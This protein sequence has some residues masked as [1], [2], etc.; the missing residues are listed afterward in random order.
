MYRIIEHYFDII[1]SD[2]MIA[3]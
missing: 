1:V 3:S 2:C